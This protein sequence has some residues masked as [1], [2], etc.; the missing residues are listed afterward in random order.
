M[1][2]LIEPVIKELLSLRIYGHRKSVRSVN[3]NCVELSSS[4][5]LSFS[6]TMVGRLNY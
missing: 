6:L 2:D 1:A 3:L 5:D 4:E